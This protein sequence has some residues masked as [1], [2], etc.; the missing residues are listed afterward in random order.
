MRYEV[1]TRLTKELKPTPT[2]EYSSPDRKRGARLLLAEAAPSAVAFGV[3]ER[4][5]AA[6]AIHLGASALQVGM[7]SAVTHLFMAVSQFYSVRLIRLLGGR[8]RML[9]ATALLSVVPFLLMALVPVVPSAAR[10]WTLVPLGALALALT[11]IGIPAWGSLVADLVPPYR[12][13]RYLGLKGSIATGVVMAVG[14]TG[15]LVLDGLGQ[16]VVWGFVAVFVVAV[17]ARLV[18]AAMLTRLADLRPDLRI[19][20]GEAPWKQLMQFGE[21]ALGKYNRFILVFHVFLG[22]VGPFMA[23]YLLRDLQISYLGFVSLW[24]VSSVTT[25]I[26]SP[27]WGRLADLRSTRLV[28]VI[29]SALMVLHPLLWVVST[30]TWHLFLVFGVMGI[31]GAGWAIS[32]YNF[33][34]ENSDEESRPAAV[35]SFE[36]M[37]SI[38]IFGGALVGGVIAAHVPTLFSHQVLTLFLLSFVLRLVTVTVLLPGVMSRRS[39][40]GASESL[41]QE[42]IARAVVLRHGIAAAWHLV[43]H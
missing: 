23:V 35:G 2:D 38:G 5:T 10:V 24:A 4:F 3:H 42:A 34:L 21:T 6:F 33:V 16:K 11:F 18:S 8:K 7:L 41:V 31:G 15:A 28:L 19:D 29:S 30:Q 25:I 17:A 40:A 12:R 37:A 13:G 27:L 36:A 22:M 9:V 1:P 20:A 39:W 43:A 14:L 26:A 32:T